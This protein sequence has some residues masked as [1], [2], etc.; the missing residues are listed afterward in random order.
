MLRIGN[1]KK[2]SKRRMIGSNFDFRAPSNPR[3]RIVVHDFAGHP[4]QFQLS[5]QLAKNGH[6]VLHLFFS[7]FAG[8]KGNSRPDAS[9][10]GSLH[11]EP[12]TIGFPME[13]YSYLNRLRAH[14]HYASAA[15]GK[16]TAF[17]PDVVLSGNT[18]TDVEYSLQ[19]GSAR[20]GARFVHWIQDFYPLALETL[21]KRKLN[22]LGG[23]LAAP[24]HLMERRIFRHSAAVV[25]I[26]PDFHEYARS[27]RYQARRETV[28]ENWAAIDELP[29]GPKDNL[30]SREHDLADKTVFLYSGTMGLKHNPDNLAALARAFADRPEIRVVLVSEGIG[31]DYLEKRKAE[32][33]LENLVLLDFQPFERLPEVMASADILLANVEPE[34][35][36]FCVPSKVLS[37]LCAGRP[38]L[39]SVPKENL[40]AKTLEKSGAGFA[41]DPADSGAFIETAK[42][43]VSDAAIRQRLGENARRYAEETF[44][45][46]RIASRFEEV[47]Q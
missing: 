9:P 29:C 45:I 34:S 47:L 13:K 33:G 3:M 43:L 10:A 11:I 30:W 7:G 38:I 14:R 15:L 41:I 35:S 44:D 2:A 6:D 36:R 24:F 25:Y 37:Y 42:R 17:Q 27:V 39:L 40:I 4:F 26:S 20:L 19:A 12:V 32:E 18:P 1:A 21:L 23:L 5:R 31:R 8:P 46:A 28:I 22:A 16:I